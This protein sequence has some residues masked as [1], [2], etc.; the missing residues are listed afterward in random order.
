MFANSV[1]RAVRAICQ[2][3]SLFDSLAADL[4]HLNVQDV[5]D[6]DP[7]HGVEFIV[8]FDTT[9]VRNLLTAILPLTSCAIFR[10]HN[11]VI[12]YA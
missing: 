12:R 1:V 9:F 4:V 7:D 11:Y 6:Q 10:F 8:S 3:G 5:Q 2:T